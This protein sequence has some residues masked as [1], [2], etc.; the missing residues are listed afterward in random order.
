VSWLVSPYASNFAFSDDQA[1]K[2]AVCE[3]KG[4]R[5]TALLTPPDFL[6]LVPRTAIDMTLSRLTDQGVVRRLAP[7]VYDFPKVSPRLG[8]LSPNADDIARAVVCKDRHV[9]QISR[10]RS[11]YAWP[12]NASSCKDGLSDGRADT[13]K[14]ILWADN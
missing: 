4:S 11:A 9:L 3:R 14:T 13:H 6:D 1:T 12:D 10:A 8:A 7:G 2:A 5:L